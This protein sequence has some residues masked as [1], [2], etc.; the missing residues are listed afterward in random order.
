MSPITEQAGSAI[1]PGDNVLVTCP[2][3]MGD[4]HQTCLELLTPAS[5]ENVY[6]LSIL[7]TQSPSDHLDSWQ[8]LV[9][10]YPARSRIVSVDADAKSSAGIPEVTTESRDGE[11]AVQRVNSPRNLTQLGVRITDSLDEWMETEPDTQVAVCFQSISTLLQYVDVEQA[12]K[13]LNVITA[14]CSAADAVAHYH[15]DP[16]AHD[17]QTTVKLEQLFDAVVE[18]D[19]DS[20]TIRRTDD[21]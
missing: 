16:H 2:S 19:E 10:A 3:F 7:F 21:R 13:F 5:P 9:G 20:W 1:H 6:A 12:F 17:E 11:Q 18:Y 8:R 4:E 14:R 15:L